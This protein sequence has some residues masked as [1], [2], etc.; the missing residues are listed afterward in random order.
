MSRLLSDIL[1]APEPHFSHTIKEWEALSGN[2]GLDVHLSLE[3]NKRLREVL[4]S[5][6]LDS[7]DT[8]DSELYH[9]L[10]V[11]AEADND[12][13]AAYL[14]ITDKD[15]PRT[16]SVKVAKF[17]KK[18][19]ASKDVWAIKQSVIKRCMSAVPPKRMMKEGGQR[20][21][22]SVLRR[23]SIPLLLALSTIIESTQWRQKFQA[24]Y[25]KLQVTDFDHRPADV[26]ILP[27]KH[28]SMLIDNNHAVHSPVVTVRELG[29]LIVIPP[30]QRFAGDV[31]ALAHLLLEGWRAVQ[32]YSA[33]Y[34]VLSSYPKFGENFVQ[35]LQQGM[36]KISHERFG[37]NWSTFHGL[38]KHD[39]NDV[40]QDLGPGMDKDDLLL[41]SAA[42]VLSQHIPEFVFWDCS[43]V[44]RPAPGGPIS[45]H[46]GDVIIN[47]VNNLPYE[48]R[49]NNSV[50]SALW[51]EFYV[52]YF[53]QTSVSEKVLN[54][55][56]D[57]ISISSKQ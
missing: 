4:N 45:C 23:E 12:S 8:T 9:A 42:L 40:W 54:Y 20:S 25:K 19:I 38:A 30:P 10:K 44:G 32:M 2:R 48:R 43:Y 3:I 13:L 49:V 36:Q 35:T 52:R 55:R 21:I 26:V 1:Q 18:H 41:P 17:L 11:R 56:T 37:A 28:L 5:L 15:T 39:D 53:S 50:K 33:F 24:Q 47:S 46:L 14:D 27:A 7:R 57:E 34:R 51:D 6:G 22:D 31:L 29:V 16:M